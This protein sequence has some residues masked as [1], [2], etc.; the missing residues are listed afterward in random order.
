VQNEVEDLFA[1]IAAIVDEHNKESSSDEDEVKRDL[2]FTNLANNAAHRFG[3]NVNAQGPSG[4]MQEYLK[5][6][7]SKSLYKKGNNQDLTMKLS[8][9]K[10][11]ISIKS[12]QIKNSN[13]LKF[14]K[15]GEIE[16]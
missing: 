10:N 5:A 7:E 9:V 15:L 11:D 13:T 12:P 6:K 16:E 1:D 4:F 2:S 14:Q 3:T 8:Y